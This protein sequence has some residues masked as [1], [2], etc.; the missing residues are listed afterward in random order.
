MAHIAVQDSDDMVAY[1]APTAAMVTAWINDQDTPSDY[2]A[3]DT[4]D[5]DLPAL[6]G[7]G[8]WFW[9]GTAFIAQTTGTI[10]YRLQQAAL[11]QIGRLDELWDVLLQ[12][13][14]HYPEREFRFAKQLIVMARFGA[15]RVWRSTVMTDNE[16]F[17]WVLQSAEGPSDLP[18]ADP[19]DVDVFVSKGYSLI[20]GIL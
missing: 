10:V 16:K 2:T 12:E 4:G 5:V 17:G 8:Q 18:T 9:Q 7:S 6:F 3:V 13:E 19:A 15:Y 1:A 11:A 20:R 14:G